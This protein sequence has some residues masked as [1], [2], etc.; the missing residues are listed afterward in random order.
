MDNLIRI[1]MNILSAILALIGLYIVVR[2]MIYAAAKSW[3]DVKENYKPNQ[4]EEK[5]NEKEEQFEKKITK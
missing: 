5:K 1:I 3:Q 2:V 4:T